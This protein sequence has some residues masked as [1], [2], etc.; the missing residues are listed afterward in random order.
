MKLNKQKSSKSK[1]QAED[2]MSVFEAT[3]PFPSLEEKKMQVLTLVLLEADS[4]DL[5]EAS[6][7]MESWDTRMWKP[8][9]HRW[10]RV[11][12]GGKDSKCLG[13]F[14]IDAGHV[15][16]GWAEF[17]TPIRALVT[18]LLLWQQR[19]QD[20]LQ[21]KGFSLGLWFQRLVS[22]V[23]GENVAAGTAERSALDPLN[24]QSQLEPQSPPSLTNLQHIKATFSNPSK[25]VP[26]TGDPNLWPMGVILFQVAPPRLPD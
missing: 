13:V 19:A 20:N 22:M 12:T 25:T 18:F 2:S 14:S 6:A 9:S 5:G 1:T 15:C 11:A 3:N 26:S 21:K 23:V 17:R 10:G 16:P 7:L 8:G 24:R 4:A